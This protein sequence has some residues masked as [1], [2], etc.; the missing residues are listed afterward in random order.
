VKAV[1]WQI[2]APANVTVLG[3]TFP[4]SAVNVGTNTNVITGF[5]T[6][7]MASDGAVVIGEYSILYSGDGTDPA[8]FLMAPT[9]PASITGS[10]AF[11]DF[12]NEELVPAGPPTDDFSEPVFGINTGPLWVPPP[13]GEVVI[14]PNPDLANASWTLSG[15]EFQQTGTGDQ[16][17]QELA[18]GDYSITWHEISGWSTPELNPP[19][20]SLIADGSITFS[21]DYVET[22]Q[23]VINPD[24][25]SLNAPWALVNT[26]GY[27]HPGNGDQTVADLLPGTYIVTWGF[28]EGYVTPDPGVQIL[29]AGGSIGFQAEYIETGTVIV[30][31]EP[32]TIAVPWTLNFPDGSSLPGAGDS[33]QQY[34]PPGFYT[35]TWGDVPGWITLAENPQTLELLS[36]ETISFSAL[37]QTVGQIEINPN[38]DQID[39]PWSVQG[40]G[41]YLETGNGDQIITAMDAGEYT[42]T[43]LD[44]PGWNAP[45][46]NPQT[47]THE[48][49][50]T[51]TVQGDYT[52]EPLLV[53]VEDIPNDQGRQVRL[54]WDRCGYDAPGY[55]YSI[56]E[57]GLYRQQGD[58]SSSLR[59]KMADWDFL[60]TVPA[61]GDD[62][63]QVVA[64]TLCDSTITGGMCLSTFIVS[65]MTDSP[66][67]Y[68]DS[69]PMSGYSLDNL[70][71]VQPTGFQVAFA[72]D[73]NDLSW[74]AP[75]DPDVDHYLVYR[76]A[77]SSRSGDEPIAQVEG[78][79]WTDP[80]EDGT[81]FGY[82]YWIA[83]V[84]H[85][86]NH[87]EATEWNATGVS[88]AEEG[89]LPTRVNL[90]SAVPN[91]FNPT[92][93][94]RFDLPT[95]Q[96]AELAIYGLDGK[97][98][99]TLINES[100]AAGS[101]EMIW[102]GRD[103][104]GRAVASGTYIYRLVAGGKVLKKS[105]TLIK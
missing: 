32:D 11:Q 55:E 41:E 4:T 93:T 82:T 20:Q 9:E 50:G 45:A 98:V 28:V 14:D 79:S 52:P 30:N 99:K 49:F 78:T 44:V 2:I 12:A 85:A 84:D 72:F 69:E 97:L 70:Q 51:V 88:G 25:D 102:N 60:G 57:Y 56:T 95:N 40:P 86:G 67:V 101:H 73:G 36:G 48:G 104:G 1:E 35:L 92:T 61:R 15:P 59:D 75:T 65:A 54:V 38:P 96:T 87:S 17:F 91:P 22:G 74:D 16:I 68:F 8:E 103:S 6:P 76:S 3:L 64:A 7:V 19:S 23:A 27:S 29:E 37:Y 66:Y 94:I 43:W 90:L 89:V 31:P 21:A 13:A 58:K 24:P 62:V 18:V 77:D 26:T 63:Y 100:L 53:S 83:A 47:I 5:G 105:M 42:L 81:G 71:P 39:A 34:L 10:M 46:M 33:T 80:V